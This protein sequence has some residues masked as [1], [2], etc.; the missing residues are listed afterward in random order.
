[1]DTVPQALPTK[2]VKKVYSSEKITEFSLLLNKLRTKVYLKSPED[3]RKLNDEIIAFDANLKKN[4]NVMQY[5]MMH[6][7][8]GS[9]ISPN[10]EAEI[11]YNDFPG[12]D[13]VEKFINSLVE[14]YS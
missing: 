9:S 10:H 8:M 12:E 7:F 2:E 14:K 5:A 1:M 6:A 3:S 11:L 13:S 4:Y